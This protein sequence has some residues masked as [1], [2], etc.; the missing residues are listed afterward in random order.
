MHVKGAKNFI[1]MLTHPLNMISK[2]LLHLL[3]A[4]KVP[5]FGLNDVLTNL[6]FRQIQ[7][8]TS[9]KE[10]YPMISGFQVYH[11]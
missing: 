1:N 4:D 2:L 6:F 5:F 10:K 11:E 9:Q 8:Q 7:F 3:F